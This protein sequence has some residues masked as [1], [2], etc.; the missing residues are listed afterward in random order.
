MYIL[1]YNLNYRANFMPPVLHMSH[2]KY[3]DENTFKQ[4]L[5]YDY[6]L[7]ACNE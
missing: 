2:F 5:S 3:F 4:F 1:M 6:T 7:H